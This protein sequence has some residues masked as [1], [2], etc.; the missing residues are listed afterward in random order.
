MIKQ[1]HR[2]MQPSIFRRK[3]KFGRAWNGCIPSHTRISACLKSRNVMHLISCSKNK[4]AWVFWIRSICSHGQSLSYCSPLHITSYYI[5]TCFNRRHLACH[6]LKLWHST[7]IKM[8]SQERRGFG[9]SRRWVFLWPCS[10]C[11]TSKVLTNLFYP[12]HRTLSEVPRLISSRW[13]D[14]MTTFPSPKSGTCFTITISPF[15]PSRV[16]FFFHFSHHLPYKLLTFVNSLLLLKSL[17][18]L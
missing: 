2:Q 12:R 1:R 15:R 17:F 4:R 11:S 7:D 13:T 8:G 3:K 6:L 14:E 18:L 16:L 10:W 5:P 9:A